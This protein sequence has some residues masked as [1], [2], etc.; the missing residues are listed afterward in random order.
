MQ[1]IAKPM[2]KVLTPPGYSPHS[3]NPNSRETLIGP[4]ATTV[5]KQRW[6]SNKSQI[7][8]KIDFLLEF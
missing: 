3:G 1:L 6:Q 7:F 8:K 5:Q 2:V 4:G